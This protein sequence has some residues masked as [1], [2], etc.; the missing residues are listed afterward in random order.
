MILHLT[1]R[2]YDSGLDL[3]HFKTKINDFNSMRSLKFDLSEI[4]HL[5]MIKNNKFI[6]D[7][8]HQ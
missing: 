3:N 8:N 4:C 2:I 7:R 6:N 1:K 5:E